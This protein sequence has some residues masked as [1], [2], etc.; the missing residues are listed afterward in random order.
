MPCEIGISGSWKVQSGRQ[1]GPHAQ[2]ERSPATASAPCGSSRSTPTA[3]PNMSD[4]R[5]PRRQ[6]LHVRPLREGHGQFDVFNMPQLRHGR[7]LPA[8]RP[9]RHFN[10][11]TGILDPRVVRFGVRVRLLGPPRVPGC[12]NRSLGRAKSLEGPGHTGPA[13]FFRLHLHSCRH[14]PTMRSHPSRETCVSPP[15]VSG[16]WCCGCLVR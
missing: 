6:V 10:E 9:A 12:E 4:P 16:C 5:F 7:Q 8:T 15:S 2:H 11:V 1:L 14:G 13:L 3:Y